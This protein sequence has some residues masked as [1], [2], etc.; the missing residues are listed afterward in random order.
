[1]C[2]CVEVIHRHYIIVVN[3]VL[4]IYYYIQVFCNIVFQNYQD[5]E[6]N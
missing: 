4:F 1:M 5:S 6:I 2:V 3:D